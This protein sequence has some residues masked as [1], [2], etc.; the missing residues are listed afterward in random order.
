[1]ALS[2]AYTSAGVTIS[3]NEISLVSGTTTLQN[4]TTDG[5]FQA[6]IDLSALA[7]GDEFEF[8]IYEKVNSAGTKR[9]C[10]PA[11]FANAQGTNNA[12]AVSP[13]LFLMHG[14]DMTLKKITGTDRSIPYSIRQIA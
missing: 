3:T 4:I 9:V 11:T 1:M 10:F 2:E 13:A 6:F 8:K 12:I 7:A 5:I 14:W